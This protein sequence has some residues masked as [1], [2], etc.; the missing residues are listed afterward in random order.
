MGIIGSLLPIALI[1]WNKIAGDSVTVPASMSGSY[2]T[3]S[4]NLFAGALCA[5]GV[6]LIGYRDTERQDR[7]TT[8]AGVRDTRGVLPDRSDRAGN[9]VRLDQL[10]SPQRREC[11]GPHARTVLRRWR[12]ESGINRRAW[13]RFV[14]EITRLP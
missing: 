12:P 3:S 2:Y 14:G 6:F 8:V 7:C 11:S 10:P 5:L 4:R 13:F 1:V 9:R